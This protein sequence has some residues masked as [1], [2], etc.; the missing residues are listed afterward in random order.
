MPIKK[1]PAVLVILLLIT[2]F[3]IKAQ[4]IDIGVFGGGSYYLGE[5]NP[6]K[7]FL[8]TRPAFGGI[9]RFNLN[10]RW[11]VRGQLLRGEIAGDD[12]V[13]KVNEMRNLRFT[14]SISELSTILE[15][16]FLEYF[17]GSSIYYFSPFLFAGPA[18]FSFNPTT[19]YQG[20][21]SFLRDLGTEG[22]T[23]D[24]KDE[25]YSLF[26]AAFAFG[27]GFKYS[28]TDRIGMNME[29]GMRK[30]F[31]DYL[32]DISRNYADFSGQPQAIIDIADPSPIKHLPGMQRGNPQNN[33]WYSFVGITLSYRFTIGEKSTCSDFD[34]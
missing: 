17:S 16:N 13:S 11:A 34:R 27:F 25:R 18:F 5:L 21:T 14:S 33:D 6:G 26:S 24:D 32:D 15:F 1:I 7:Q 23:L 20:A 8:Y 9:V 3:P 12:A 30:T 31:T 29:W 28:V 2:S 10:D 22:Q 4:D 19:Q